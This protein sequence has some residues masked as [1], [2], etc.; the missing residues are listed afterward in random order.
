MKKSTDQQHVEMEQF[1]N[2]A[3]S[4]QYRFRHENDK[5]KN[6]HC[7]LAGPVDVADR[8]E[9]QTELIHVKKLQKKGAEALHIF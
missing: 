2:T 5:R 9:P 7:K 1:V 4:G 6:Y 8:R 3:P